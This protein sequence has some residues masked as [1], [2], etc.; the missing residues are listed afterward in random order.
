MESLLRINNRIWERKTTMTK[1]T[2]LVMEDNPSDRAA[3]L[4]LLQPE[5]YVAVVSSMEEAYHYLNHTIPDLI[6]LDTQLK[7]ENGMDMISQLRGHEVYCN[8]PMILITE[9]EGT[10][11]GEY[12]LLAGADDFVMK[13]FSTTVFLQRIY[14][15]LELEYYRKSLE[16][17]VSDQLKK[18]VYL[19]QEI[20]ITMANLIESRDGTTGEHVKRSAT[21]VDYLVDRMV[22]KGIYADKLDDMFIYYVKKSAPLHDLGKI[23]V[24]DSILRKPA[25]LTSEEKQIVKLHASNG[26]RLIRD[27]MSGM[28][29]REFVDVAADM[30]S[31]HHERWD[32]TGYPK[33]LKGEEIPL[34]ARIM[35]IAD[36]F[37]A[38]SSKRHYKDALPFEDI[39]KI[40]MVE[41]KEHFEPILLETFFEDKERLRELMFELHR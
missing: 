15:T 6:L 20:I 26:G 7:K 14:K 41:E 13:P 31:Y 18:M 33:G 25:A 5:F 40:M 23:A 19:Q 1:Q 38:L 28:A 35:A 3:I 4:E 21:Y 24:S 22:E 36:V 27:N 11:S 2:I 32:G 17:L 29:E 12:C 8:I 9:R 37:D 39:C 16:R 10:Y 34:E 30:A